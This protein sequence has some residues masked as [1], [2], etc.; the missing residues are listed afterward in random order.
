MMHVWFINCTLNTK[1]TLG[2]AVG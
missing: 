2:A 1:I